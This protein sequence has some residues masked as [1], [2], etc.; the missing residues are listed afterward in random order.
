M[1]DKLFL[2]ALIACLFGLIFFTSFAFA[3]EDKL[4]ENY[5]K[6]VNI[7]GVD[8]LQNINSNVYN[9]YNATAGAPDCSTWQGKKA[10]MASTKNNKSKTH[11]GGIKVNFKKPGFYKFT[12]YL[13]PWKA[14]FAYLAGAQIII[15]GDTAKDHVKI[16][17]T[18]VRKYA[19]EYN[20]SQEIIF[21]ITHP[22]LYHIG[23]GPF[24]GT[25]LSESFAHNA[26]SLNFSSIRFKLES[27]PDSNDKNF[28]IIKFVDLILVDSKKQQYYDLTILKKIADYPF[29]A[30]SDNQYY[31]LISMIPGM[32][33][34]NVEIIRQ[35]LAK[36]VQSGYS[37]THPYGK[38]INYVIDN[39]NDLNTVLNNPDYKW[40]N[41]EFKDVAAAKVGLYLW[42]MSNYD[43][44]TLVKIN[45]LI[46]NKKYTELIE[47]TKKQAKSFLTKNYPS[48][49]ILKTSKSNTF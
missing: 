45:S 47:L 20:K 5:N 9:Y 4:L 24:M 33:K 22:G 18:S 27:F 46:I 31:D 25:L 34:N 43:K 23:F 13:E 39:F 41:P 38:E 3:K 7:A 44:S 1:L 10:I 2:F 40:N 30:P 48:F 19:Y 49:Q 17:K 16:P 37:T 28:D 29:T 6:V 8:V 36:A 15:I 14:K 35:D 26:K 42:Q 11:I 32:T 21:D 12:Y